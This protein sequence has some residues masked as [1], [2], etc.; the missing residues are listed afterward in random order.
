MLFRFLHALMLV[1]YLVGANITPSGHS[2]SIE[3]V[4]E[5]IDCRKTSSAASTNAAQ[6]AYLLLWLDQTTPA[7][8]PLLY[9]TSH[10]FAFLMV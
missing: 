5:A 2:L 4:H 1:C 9:S 6:M 7:L 10:D 8:K 3:R